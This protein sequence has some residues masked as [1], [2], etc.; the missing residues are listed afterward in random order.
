[1]RRFLLKEAVPDDVPIVVGGVEFDD[2]NKRLIGLADDIWLDGE[3]ALGGRLV[4]A[5]A[6]IGLVDG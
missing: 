1:M 4:L 5:A 2:P 3:G 6:G